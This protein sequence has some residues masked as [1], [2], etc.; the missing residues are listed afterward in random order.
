MY[1]DYVY[2]TIVREEVR[3]RF[4]CY[5]ITINITSLYY[6]LRSIITLQANYLSL[7]A[8]AVWD[9]FFRVLTLPCLLLHRNDKISSKK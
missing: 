7:T 1:D 6:Y 9:S 8:A 3:G 4:R 5:S 2:S